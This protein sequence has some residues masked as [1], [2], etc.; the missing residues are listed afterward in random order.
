MPASSILIV[1]LGSASSLCRLSSATKENP[2]GQVVS[3]LTE[4]SAKV[5]KEG[6]AEAKSFKEYAEWCDDTLTNKGFEIKTA[7]STQESLEAKISK[8]SGDIDT[9]GA[10]ITELAADIAA[11][12]AELKNATAIRDGEAADFAASEKELLEVIDTLGRAISLISK[13]MSKKGSVFA[14]LDSKDFKGFLQSLD[15]LVDAAALTGADKQRLTALVQS[16]HGSSETDDDEEFGAPAAAVYESHSGSILD[17]L[18]DLKEKAEEQ[19]SSL[20]KSEVTAKHNYEM[21]KQSLEDQNAVDSK[22]LEEEKTN[23]AS[24]SESLAGAEGDLKTTVADLKASE[25]ALATAKDT[26]A[27]V[28]A[29]H[30]ATVAARAEELKVIGEAIEILKGTTSGGVSQAYSFLQEATSSSSGFRIRTRADMARSEVLVLIK[31]LAQQQH[32]AALAQLASRVMAVMRYSAAGST[33][34]P[35]DKVKTLITDMISKL[36]A[37]A[38]SEA[39]EKSFCDEETAQSEVKKA[40]LEST[41]SKLATKMDANAANSASLKADVQELS[42]ELANLAKEEAEMIK[43]R[44]TT[45]GDYIQAKADYEQGLAG[46]RKALVLLREYYATTG[47]VALV[48]GDGKLGSF[49]QQ[50]EKP[51]TFGKSAGSA[52]NII[53]ILEVVESDFATNLAKAETAE[54]TA[55]EAHEKMLQENKIT[56]ATKKQDIKYKTAESASLDKENAELASDHETTGT[57][58][59]AVLEYLEKLNGRCVAKPETYETRKQR[60][61]AEIDGLKEAL[62]VLEEETAFVQKAGRQQRNHRMRGSLRVGA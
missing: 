62:S 9:T 27:E 15:S 43:M 12:S 54:A 10:K 32:S 4:L 61:E 14:Q 41:M 25:T 17:T 26:C 46:V 24:A 5:A 33:E 23:K 13:E 31:K 11:S 7:K 2:L 6:E 55:Q 19:L 1:L 50:P 39:T 49:M 42:D 37:E 60:R 18:E 34:G 56:K 48:Q 47:E 44:G 29:D 3:L 58:H 22:D 35:F 40:D 51:E 53:G 20:R 16:T 36:E 52:T 30:D 8:L 38:S 21:V 45:H 28:S 59:A 57:E